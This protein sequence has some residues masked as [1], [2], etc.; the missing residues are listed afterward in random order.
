M[1]LYPE[2]KVCNTM[3]DQYKTRTEK[4]KYEKSKKNNK[5]KK[6]SKSSLLKRTL[7]VLAALFII[8]GISVG[9]VFAY[10]AV[11]APEID[12]SALID[13]IS[14]KI[15]DKNGDIYTEIGSETRDYVDYKDVPKLMENAILA[16]EDVRFY[17]H[18]GIDIIRVGGALMET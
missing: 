4:R 11:T 3:S 13:P 2:R 15:Y 7:I 9:G 16:T 12:D 14:S 10:W 18:H 5:Q 8:A 1:V 6:Q 17:K